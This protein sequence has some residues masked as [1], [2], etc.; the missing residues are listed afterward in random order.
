MTAV[1]DEPEFDRLAH[2][3]LRRIEDAFVDVDPDQIDV[4]AS[5]GVV[6][7]TLANGTN[8]QTVTYEGCATLYPSPLWTHWAP[9]R[10]FA[11]YA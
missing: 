8:E 4:S 5:D 3:T 9:R 6:R 2:A 10:Q 1:L 11:P 7:L